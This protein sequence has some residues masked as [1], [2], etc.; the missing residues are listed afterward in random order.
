MGQTRA[1]FSSKCFFS[2]TLAH[3][4]RHPP[5]LDGLAAALARLVAAG[6][7]AAAA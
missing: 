3:S 1:Y 7:G 6:Q 2:F 5:A 4:S